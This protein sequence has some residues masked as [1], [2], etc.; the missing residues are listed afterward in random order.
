VEYINSYHFNQYYQYYH[1]YLL[2][3]GRTPSHREDNNSYVKVYNKY[4]PVDYNKIYDESMYIKVDHDDVNNNHDHNKIRNSTYD[5]N[6]N[7]NKKIIDDKYKHTF[8]YDYHDNNNNNTDNDN[9]KNVKFKINLKISYHNITNLN[10]ILQNY[11]E[12]DVTID[13]YKQVEKKKRYP[14]DKI[15]TIVIHFIN[16]Y[17][18][19]GHHHHHNHHS[20]HH[21][22]HHHHHPFNHTDSNDSNDPD[23]HQNNSHIS[24]IDNRNITTIIGKT[25]DEFLVLHPWWYIEKEIDLYHISSHIPHIISAEKKPISH[26]HN[27]F[28]IVLKKYPLY[29]A[30]LRYYYN[31]MRMNR[32]ISILMTVMMIAMLLLMLNAVDDDVAI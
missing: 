12:F 19:Y 26:S 8:D 1:N 30:D 18:D 9:N 22:D 16:D 14:D 7:N 29:E 31:M 28:T 2:S 15:Q 6:I 4:L 23:L 10:K 27:D 21:E 13:N 17:Q 24:P 3:T 5:K 32:N 20:F 25:V 11:I